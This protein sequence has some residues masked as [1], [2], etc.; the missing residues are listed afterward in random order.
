VTYEPTLG[1]LE[2]RGLISAG[3]AWGAALGPEWRNA[4]ARQAQAF[5]RDHDLAA[6][7]ERSTIVAALVGKFE[8][9]RVLTDAVVCEA[10]RELYGERPPV[11]AVAAA[12]ATLANIERHRRGERAL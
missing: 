6:A 12:V 3:D 4:T 1:E 11:G 2:E 8:Q 9:G 10:V 5:A 7:R